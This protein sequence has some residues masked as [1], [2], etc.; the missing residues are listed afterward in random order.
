MRRGLLGG[1]GNLA[2][3]AAEAASMQFTAVG[4]GPILGP[5]LKSLYRG[6]KRADYRPDP[7]VADHQAGYVG[8]GYRVVG[9]SWTFWSDQTVRVGHVEMLKMSDPM[10]G[11]GP[12]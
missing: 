8:A 11:V 7:M 1:G 2:E 3:A 10:V 6:P 4:G 9:P 5:V 12:V